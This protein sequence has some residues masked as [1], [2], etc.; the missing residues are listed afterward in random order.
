MYSPEIITTFSWA[1]AS[2]A[3]YPFEVFPLDAVPEVEGKAVLVMA[4]WTT[5]RRWRP[6]LIDDCGDVR[7]YLANVQRISY[8]KWLGC[9]HV[10]VHRGG[11]LMQRRRE[12]QDLLDRWDPPGNPRIL[13]R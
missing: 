1:G 11:T 9:T 8:L 6:L 5:D 4:K 7:A 2:G 12:R 3:L 13:T 10:H